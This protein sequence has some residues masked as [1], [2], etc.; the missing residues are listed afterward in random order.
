LRE[1]E[2]LAQAAANAFSA[3]EAK[4]AALAA[5]AAAAE[6]QQREAVAALAN[7]V[8]AAG[9]SDTTAYELA[10][11]DVVRI[12]VLDAELATARERRTSATDRLARARAATSGL[13]TPDLAGLQEAEAAAEQAFETAGA[14]LA[15][16]R[17]DLE[18][19]RRLAGEVSGLAPQRAA[20]EA[21]YGVLQRLAD[22]A[23]GKAGGYKITFQRFILGALLDEVL[24]AASQ[25]LRLMSQGRYVLRRLDPERSG[26]HRSAAAGLDLEVDDAWTGKTRHVATLSGGEGFLAALALA[27]GLADVV[28]TRAGGRRLDTLFID[29]GFGALDSEALDVALKVLTELQRDGRL[30]GVISH[31]PELRERIDVRL[32]VTKGERGSL[33]RFRLP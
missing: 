22:V 18:L 14:A 3:A 23:M 24:D 20:L 19:L 21:R 1:A 13:T 31:V 7:A 11:A 12:D 6:R 4:R 28:Q 30:V 10:Q 32:E 27:L 5:D 15:G 2:Q 17:K 25:R 33:A 16:Q 8:R 9:F 26:G 29:E